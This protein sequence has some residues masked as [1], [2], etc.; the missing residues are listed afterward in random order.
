MVSNLVSIPGYRIS[1]ELYNGSRTLVYRAVRETD[2]VPVVIK[3]LKNPY[4]SFS[5]LLLFRN[6]YTIGKNLNSPLIIQTYSLDAINNGYMLIMEDFGGISLKEYFSKNQSFISVE[7]FLAIAI[8]LCDILNLL[9]HERIIHKDIKP[10]NIL[11]NPETKQ[12]KLIDFSIASLLPRETQ[13]L[14]NPNVLE[15]TLAYISPEQTGRMNRGIDYRTDFYSLG[16]T[17][18]ELLTGELPF[19]SNDAMELVHSHIAK[20]PPLIHEMNP[21]IPSV[22]LEIIRKLMA[23]NAEDRYQSALGLKLDLEKCLTQ[24]RETGEISS[25]EIASRDV[26]D[27]FIIPD[28]LYGREAE[29]QTLLEAFERVSQGTTEMMLVAGFSGIGK[30]AVVNEVHKPIVRQRGYFIK[31]KFD[32]FNRNIPFSAFVQAFRDLIGQLLTESDTQLQQWKTQISAALG[33]NAQVIV[34]L[35]PELEQIIGAQPP[36]AEL[37]GTAA[38]NRFNL[39]FQRFIQVFTTPLHPLVMFVDDLQW[40]DSASLNLIQV[41]MSESQTGCLLLLGA[42][43]DNE[44]FAAHPLILSLNEMEKT[45]AKIDTITLQ[46]L[47]FS[48]L[49]H[50][51]ADTLHAPTSVVQ[52]LTEL[53]IQK[54]QGNP[55]FATQFL[56]ALHQDQLITFDWGAGHWQC[57]IVQVRDAALTDDVVELMAQQLQ[58]LPP[59]TQ[60]I[61]KLAACIGANFDLITLAIVSQQ[62]QTEVA[63]TLWK[64][65][66]EGLILPQSDLYK[67]YLSETQATQDT[68]QATLQ[69]K[70]LHDRVQQAAYS[71]IPNDQKQTTHVKIGRLLWENT[72]EAEIEEQVFAIANQLNIGIEQFHEP[73]ERHQLSRLNFIAGKKAKAST[74]YNAALAYLKISIELLPLNP[75]QS[76]YDFT[77]SLYNEA[78]EASYLSGELDLMENFAQEVLQQA[79]AIIDTAKVYEI[80]I[81]SYTIQSQFLAAIDTAMQFLQ[82]IGIEF[83]SEPTDLDFFLGLQEIQ[84][85]LSDKTVAEL[86][87]LPEMQQ[88]E[89]RTALRVL[90]KVDT[91]AYLGKPLL[92]RL[93]VPK[94][95]SLSIK[96]GNTSASSF[97]YSGYGLMLSGQSNSILPGY[98]FGQLALQLLSK[99]SDSEYEARVLVV[100]HGFITHWKEPLTATLKPLLQA[101]ARGLEIGDLAFACHG[102][103]VYCYHAYVAGQELT[104]LANEL[105]IYGAAL[106]KIHKQ[107]TLN[108][109]NIYHQIVLNLIEPTTTPWELVGTAYDENSMLLLNGQAR[110]PNSLWHFCVNK[111]ML[112]YLFQVLDLAVEY[113]IKAK[114]CQSSGLG[115]AMTNISLLN[116]YD[117]LVQLALYPT[118]SSTEQQQILQQVAENQQIMQQW[119]NYA[120]MNQLHRFYLVEAEKHQVLGDKTTAI[121]FYD[122]AISCAKANGYIQEEA[123]ANELAAKFYLNWEKEKVAA[124]YMQEAYY[125]YARWGAKAKVVDLETR[126]PQLLS[127]I[128]QPSR[129]VLS[130]NE[131]IFPLGN[132][133]SSSAATSSSTS[134]SDTLDLKAILKASQAISGEIELDKL[135]LSLLSIII[136]N[137]GADKCVLMLLQDNHLLIQGAIT[138]GTK[139]VVL[140]SLA[141]E[142][143]QDIPHKLIYKVK[144]NQ[145]TLVLLDATTDTTLA[146]DPYII[147]Q[148][149]QSILCSPILHQGKLLGILYLENSLAKGAFTSDRVELLNLICAQAAIS[150]ENAQLYQRSQ[151][152]AQEL[153]QAL[154]NLQQAQLQIVQS[155][156]MSALG[157]L[158]AGV[159]HEMNNPLGFI[160]ASLQQAKPTLT[161]IVEH[162][163]LYQATFS[164]KTEEILDHEAEIDLEYSLEDLPKMLDSMTMACDRLKNISTS[165]RTFSRA[166]RDYKV[167]FNL[168]EGIDSTILILKHRL[169]ANEQRPAIEVITNYGD[170][171]LVEC[172]PGQLNQVFMNILANAIDALDESNNGR[173]FQDIQTNPNRITL[174]TSRDNNLVKITIA[175]NGKGM[176]EEVKHKI[177]DHL[178]T[179]KA[180]GKGTGLGLAIA[181]QIVEETHGG[182][183]NCQSILGKGTE[184]I[185]EIPV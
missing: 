76:N 179:T 106:A 147:R 25:F 180:V 153:E 150:L 83:P 68:S 149:P 36:A 47:N 69:Y 141:I 108:Y 30:T 114:Q 110:D 169:K 148:Q 32:Q 67:F 35:I 171:P 158:V 157:N 5:E 80:K 107:A 91:P 178:F 139:P 118:A 28:K 155:E 22:I 10:S 132:V 49:N 176:S 100:V 50:L 58:K 151:Q 54:T 185:I 62:S 31:G 133:T 45:G 145:Q 166:D 98:E 116:F 113:A 136:E 34:E 24:L 164:D 74:A 82:P 13:T 138:Q 52:P 123:L 174:T 19:S 129:S 85:L 96:Y 95:L 117:S 3:L 20:M 86:A 8:A 156:K 128:L 66:Q 172:F 181:Q 15:G 142:D 130:T 144:H 71:L 165:L 126:Y 137:A 101:Y 168:H 97:V 93:L 43:R 2:S 163:Q 121:E 94:E 53:V 159:A 37:S 61:L 162:L 92:H 17:F 39:L 78:T 59:A 124:G 84:A 23:K 175:D 77:L 75:W 154:H 42:Y 161:D 72:P 46:P 26:C 105:A 9:Y 90:V 44:V 18:Y 134:I 41:L 115:Y 127:P 170:L 60:E 102:A 122:R 167:P 33:E 89:L 11:I 48:S 38:Q 16:V 4:P 12:V 103:S 14:V 173:S 63:T 112:C 99:F 111:L 183:L 140:Q 27:R 65:L 88:P 184:F 51:I 56:K 160:A 29:V 81:E 55:F 143:S 1:E 104:T 119:A 125:C 135:L 120:P 6:Q 87:D 40:A 177:F 182:K 146:N 70:F 152:Y 57:D 7:E 131:T 21:D 73:T 64:A 79:K 109:H